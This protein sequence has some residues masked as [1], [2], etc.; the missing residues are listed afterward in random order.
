M[1]RV[2]LALAVCPAG[3]VAIFYAWGSLFGF[4]LPVAGMVVWVA[5]FA[6]PAAILLGLPAHLLLGTMGVTSALAYGVAGGVVGVAPFI[7]WAMQGS[8]DGSR[9]IAPGGLCGIGAALLFWRI[10][11]RE[12]DTIPRTVP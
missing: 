7:V 3:A 1:R 8:S 11:V 12:A 9:L 2:L 6:Y 10:A 5:A 4:D